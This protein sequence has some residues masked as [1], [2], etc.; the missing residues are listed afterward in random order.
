MPERRHAAYNRTGIT[1]LESTCGEQ[2]AVAFNDLAF[3]FNDRFQ[4]QNTTGTLSING[5]TVDA[6][7]AY[8]AYLLR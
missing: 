2:Y 5:L 1:V 8:L 3:N 4:L 7:N 6:D